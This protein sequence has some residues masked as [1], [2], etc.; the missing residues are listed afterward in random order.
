ME[1]H[2]DKLQESLVSAPPS[3][4]IEWEA[5]E[6]ALWGSWGRLVIRFGRLNNASPICPCPNPQNLWVLVFMAK[7]TLQMWL[8]QGSW[9]GEAILDYLGEP[10]V[11]L[12]WGIWEGTEEKVMYWQ[13]QRLEWCDS[14]M[15]KEAISH[16][17]QAATRSWKRQENWFFPSKLPKGANPD[18]PWLHPQK[19]SSDFWPQE[20]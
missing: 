2:L 20:I 8:N 1:G 9:D 19:L 12:T 17:I 3:L 16:G 4:S 11:I 6:W 5:S 15:K 13:K 14:M 10:D 18:V 7:G